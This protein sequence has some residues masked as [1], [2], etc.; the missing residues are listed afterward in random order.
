MRQLAA[1]ERPT[2]PLVKPGGAGGAGGGGA[3]D[4]GAAAEGRRRDKELLEARR[5]VA[6]AS[7]E[8]KKLRQALH[9]ELGLAEGEPL[10]LDA[11]L[12]D[13]AGDRG[14]RGRAETIVLLRSKVDETFFFLP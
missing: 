12:A 2:S 9:R 11:L 3:E 10:P 7:E 5:R 14:W 8:A 1:G 13:D 4:E 6:K